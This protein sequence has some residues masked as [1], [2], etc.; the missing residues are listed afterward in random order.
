MASR[1]FWILG[2]LFA[3]FLCL[4]AAFPCNQTDSE[5]KLS[6]KTLKK[7]ESEVRTHHKIP[8]DRQFAVLHLPGR[9]PSGKDCH[10]INFNVA[11]EVNAYCNFAPSFTEI[12][13][14]KGKEEIKYTGIYMVHRLQVNV[15]NPLMMK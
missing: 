10:R 12:T 9:D 13:D 1:F 15:N 8:A 6:I 3:L 5:N 11:G 7:M 2:S 4:D 14:L